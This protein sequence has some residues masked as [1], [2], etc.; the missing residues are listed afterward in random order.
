MMKEQGAG[1]E[2]PEACARMASGEGV[3]TEGDKAR[4][5]SDRG[6]VT[7]SHDLV[8]VVGFSVKRKKRMPRQRRPSSSINHLFSFT[9]ATVSSSRSSSTTT[10]HVPSSSHLHHLLSFPAR[11]ID[12]RRLSFLFRKE[13]KNSDVSSLKRM[14]LPKKAAEAHLPLLESK[15]GIFISMDDLDGLHVWNFKYRY[16]PNNSSRM[17][18]LENTGEFVNTHG[19]QL[20]D[21]IVVYKDDQNQNYVIQAKKASDQ[22]LYANIATNAVNDIFFHDY[23]VNK[24]SSFYMNYPME[25]NTG[26]SF[27]YDTTTTTFSDDSP[28]D[29]LCGS[30]TSYSRM[31][32]MES[33]GSVESLPLDEFN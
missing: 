14:I 11:V 19:L 22:D 13:L 1:H 29:F 31:G 6:G 25:D 33:F 32:H 18:V 10:S 27:I 15:E 12:Q 9:A 24:S 8:S 7:G 16:W 26:L 30:L 17:Y 5:G 3:T 21:F 28:L 2:K 20:G 23:E 4:D